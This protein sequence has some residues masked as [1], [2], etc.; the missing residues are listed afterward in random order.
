MDYNGL[1]WDQ[2]QVHLG[3]NPCGNQILVLKK[4]FSFGKKKLL[5][6][7]WPN[8]QLPHLDGQNFIFLKKK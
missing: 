6:G 4:E 5:L 3:S 2:N 7:C 8:S 1:K